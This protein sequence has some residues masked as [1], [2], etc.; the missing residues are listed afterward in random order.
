VLSEVFLDASYAIALAAPSDQLHSRAVALAE[1]LEADRSRLVTTQA[2]VLEIGNALSKRRYRMAAVQLISSLEA[3]PSV[4][5]VPLSSQL[6][7]DAFELFRKRPD[8]EWGLIDCLSFLVM[9]ARGIV[10][11]LTADEHFEQAGFRVLLRE[12]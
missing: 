4:E 10:D 2:V 7:A 1:K 9:E 5:I 11:A 3:D 8:K 12:S 6:F